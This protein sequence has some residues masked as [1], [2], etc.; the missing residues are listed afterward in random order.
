MSS[1]IA[2][3]SPGVEA[4][5]ARWRAPASPAPARCCRRR[6]SSR[7]RRRRPA[8]R[9][10]VPH[11]PAGGAID[12]GGPVERLGKARARR[13]PMTMKSWTSTRRPAWAPPPKIWISGSGSTA[14]SRAAEMAPE[15]HARRGR[16]GV[17]HG[18]RGRDQRVAAE[19]RLVRRAVERDQRAGRPP[20]G[21]R[22]PCR[23]APGRSR[24]STA[25][26]APRTSWPPKRRAA[27]AQVD[28][29]AGARRGAGRRDGAPGRAAGER[30]LDLDG[31]PAAR[32]PDAAAVHARDGGFGHASAGR[33]RAQARA[34]RG[35]RVDGA[36][37]SSRRATPPDPVLVASTVT[38][39]TGDLP[40]TRAE[41]QRRQQ[42]AA[43]ASSR[44]RRL[45][46]DARRDRSSASA[47]KQSRNAVPRRSAST[48]ISAAGG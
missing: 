39:S 25:A 38:Y 8:S 32:I 43:R 22:R 46:V 27:V 13:R 29:L 4:R 7:P 36:A 40:S 35:E 31:R 41:Q 47:S 48:G 14:P 28:R 44:R 18:H 17:G 23:R 16:G 5:R 26:T 45:P 34:H 10:C 19:P 30:H 11:Q 2:T 37:S 6:A 42:R 12:L 24:A 33:L 20:P 15:R 1:E 21:R 3:S 9:P